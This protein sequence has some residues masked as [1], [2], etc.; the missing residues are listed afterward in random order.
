M[1][2]P[3]MREQFEARKIT[4]GPAGWIIIGMEFPNQGPADRSELGYSSDTPSGRY[5]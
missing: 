3:E 2:T 5:V 4:C 1:R